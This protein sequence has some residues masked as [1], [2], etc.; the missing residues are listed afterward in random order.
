MPIR[1]EQTQSIP[2]GSTGSCAAAAHRSLGLQE[3]ADSQETLSSVQPC[4]VGLGQDSEGD[5]ATYRLGGTS[6]CLSSTQVWGPVIPSRLW[7]RLGSALDDKKL[8][9]GGLHVNLEQNKA[10]L[11]ILLFHHQEI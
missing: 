1:E 7:A 5:L 9:W 10:K 6:L 11:K 4:L 2:H 3:K 8:H